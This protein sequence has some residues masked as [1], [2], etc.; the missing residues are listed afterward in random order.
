MIYAAG[1]GG[2]TELI[3]KDMTKGKPMNLIL[4][5]A[6]PL[7]IGSV[8]QQVYNFVDVMIVGRYLGENALAGVGST[9]NLTMFLLALI[10]GL[11]NG[12]GIIVSQC[13]GAGDYGRMRRAI[14]SIIWVASV[15]TVLV[16][17]VGLFFTDT[18][19]RIL[20]VPEHVVA[21]SATYLKILYLFVAGSVAYNGCAAILRS[22]G[23]SKTPLYALIIASILNIGL[24]LFFV[25][26]LQMGVSGVALATVIS[27]HVSAGFCITY[28]IR[29]RERFGLTGLHLVPDREMVILIFRMGVP[30]AF[31]SC[32]IS[33][34]GMSVQRL[35]N[36]F[37]ASVMAAYAAAVKID[38]IAIQV[39]VSLGTALSVFTGQN[40]GRQRYDRI[41]E[42]MRRTLA[43]T[44][45]ASVTIAL[46]AF[47]FGR[48]L[49]TIFLDPVEASNAIGTGAT[50]LSIMGAAYII[51]GIM[52]SYQNVIRGSGD[53][54][55]CMAAGFAELA[56]RIVFAYLLSAYIGVTGIWI[57][58]P[59]SWACGCIVPVVRYYSGKW[60]EKGVVK[61]PQAA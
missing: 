48:N 34:G 24:D 16:I 4:S 12:A 22:L 55:T 5:F 47:F 9:G 6:I 57:A 60:K 44:G 36:S 17:I 19:L 49:M 40:M 21:Y 42:G 10:M 54:N 33:L 51:C 20:Q 23:D 46:I 43:M 38:N 50:Y 28:L 3:M 13:F 61:K 32:L 52:Q 8:F 14:S 27:Q 11:C 18:F 2:G 58:T 7:L 31:Q 37:G 1:S 26:Q 29:H 35:I 53:V 39:I 59:L 45:I 56:G 30:T 25:L 41:R 15:L